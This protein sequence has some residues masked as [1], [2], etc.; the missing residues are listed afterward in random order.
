V[1]RHT[2]RYVTSVELQFN[3]VLFLNKD[4]VWNRHCHQA[5]LY[6]GCD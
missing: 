3:L 4:I 2:D 5:A 6:G 1:T